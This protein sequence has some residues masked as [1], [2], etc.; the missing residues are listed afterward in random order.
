MTFAAPWFLIFLLPAAAFAWWRLR[1]LTETAAAFSAIPAAD[2]P[3]TPKVRYA[4]VPN[5]LRAA[6]L[7]F[8]VLALAQPCLAPRWAR[9]VKTGTSILILLDNSYSMTSG[10]LR[11]IFQ[12]TRIGV[13]K[14]LV[15][16]LIDARTSDRISVIAFSREPKTLCPLTFS[17]EPVIE[18]IRRLECVRWDEKAGTAVGDAVELGAARFHA[19]TGGKTKHAAM[20][21][22][23]DGESTHGASVRD[24]AKVAAALGMK[25]YVIHLFNAPAVGSPGEARMSVSDRYAFAL[26]LG[27]GLRRWAARDL[28]VAAKLTGGKYFRVGNGGEAEAVAREIAGLEKTEIAERRL[29]GGKRLAPWL[30]LAALCTLAAEFALRSTWLR[31][32]P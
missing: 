26:P 16:D 17:R 20:V 1:R 11:G 31:R 15:L 22:I 29:T 13:A 23:T 18:A 9:E 25:L 8:A 24:A 27:E 10:V 12:T 32:T 4:F 7:G 19:G 5:A 14:R 3:R 21:L 2:L 6:G 30:A 28:P